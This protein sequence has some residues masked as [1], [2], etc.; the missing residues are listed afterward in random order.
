MLGLNPHLNRKNAHVNRKISTDIFAKA[1]VIL[2]YRTQFLSQFL[3]IPFL[4]HLIVIRS[5][6][7]KF[8]ITSCIPYDY[9]NRNDILKLV[10]V[11]IHQNQRI[12]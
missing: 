5:R 11:I 9:K 8:P 3:Y 7:M 4:D 10:A 1:T 12:G 2:M 6:S